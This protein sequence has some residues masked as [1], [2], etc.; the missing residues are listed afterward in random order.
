M[1]M[2]VG[3][4][5]DGNDAG[6][7]AG[8]ARIAELVLRRLAA[9]TAVGGVLGLLVAAR[10]PP[11][12]H[13]VVNLLPC[14][15]IEDRGEPSVADADPAT[16]PAAAFPRPRLPTVPLT[17][18]RPRERTVIEPPAMRLRIRYLERI[19][20]PSPRAGTACP[21][22]SVGSTLYPRTRPSRHMGDATGG[23]P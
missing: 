15:F 20:R 22:L 16:L 17:R 2:G 21:A 10:G 11:L 9:I 14:P 1:R 5:T 6:F 23:C 3:V 8:L 4:R 19:R 7:V 13:G 12:G 18:R